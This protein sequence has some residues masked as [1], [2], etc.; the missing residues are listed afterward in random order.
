MDGQ[1]ITETAYD[2]QNQEITINSVIGDVE[3]TITET[4]PLNI[5]FEALRQK[6]LNGLDYSIGLNE[7]LDMMNPNYSLN[8]I[9][10]TVNP[11]QEKLGRVVISNMYD[12]HF[13]SNDGLI[14]FDIVRDD[15]PDDED[16][17]TGELIP[18]YTD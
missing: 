14:E 12:G 16:P 15:I 7:E 17:E 9:D 6:A 8:L 2:D 13:T 4:I 5:S 11:H 3:I 1:D 18:G 10:V